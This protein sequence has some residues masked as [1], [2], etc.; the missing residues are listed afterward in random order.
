MHRRRSSHLSSLRIRTRSAA[1]RLGAALFFSAC[2]PA[3]DAPRSDAELQAQVDR[4]VPVVEKAV[5]LD[6]KRPPRVESRSRDQVRGFLMGKLEAEL[7]DLEDMARAY[8]LFGIVPDSLDLS[9][10]LLDVYTE[11]VVG[12]YD[13]DTDVLYTVEGADQLLRRTT[14]AHELVHALQAQYADLHEMLQS[15]PYAS[16]RATALQAV[17]EGQATI[18]SLRVMMPEQDLSALGTF[19]DDVRRMIQTQQEAM[20][21]FSRSPLLVREALVFPYLA[22]ADFVRWYDDR[23]PRT[24]LAFGEKAPRSTEQILH[25]TKYGDEDEPIELTFGESSLDDAV[26]YESQFGELGIRILMAELAGREEIRT[27][28]PLSW[29]GDRF[30]VYDDEAVVW[31]VLWDHAGARD[32][33]MRQMPVLWETGPG[34]RSGYRTAWT[35]LEV[36][37]HPAVRLVYG[38]EAW[39]GWQQVPEVAVRP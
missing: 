1:A 19:W 33:F 15:N 39:V 14:L 2:A 9:A 11:Q 26:S 35:A 31:Y 29:G 38:P 25:P 34:A 20:P 13:P 22:G 17:I 24:R 6:F 8:K 37:G 4:L 23:Y 10:L 5:G 21:V 16:D 7:D 36:G 32:R 27:T 30:R 28:V 3:Q 12:F 18:Y